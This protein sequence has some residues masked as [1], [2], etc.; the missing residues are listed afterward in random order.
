MEA[1][2]SK[3][4]L[5]D[6]DRRSCR[7]GR[8]AG[9]LRRTRRSIDDWRPEDEAFW[10]GGGEQVARRNLIWSVFAEHL[11]LLGLA[12]LESAHRGAA[13]EGRLPLLGATTLRPGRQCQISSGR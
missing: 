2:T 1:T 3:E 13:A 8:S 4:C 10:E 12:A 5:H 7:A 9:P 11:G 6:H